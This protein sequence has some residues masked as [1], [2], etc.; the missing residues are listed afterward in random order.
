MG[1]QKAFQHTHPS[2]GDAA[3]QAIS[4]AQSILFLTAPI[5][6]TR[7]YKLLNCSIH[8]ENMPFILK[9]TQKRFFVYLELSSQVQQLIEENFKG[10]SPTETFTGTKVDLVGKG[11]EERR[12]E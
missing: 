1:I 4:I 7:R 6:S 5:C 10:R 9:S 2:M 3:C 8:A 12:I 11:S